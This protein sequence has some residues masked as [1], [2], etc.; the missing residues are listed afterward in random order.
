MKN[1]KALL[2]V[3]LGSPDRPRYKEVREYLSAFLND[4]RIIDIP[5]IFRKILV[6][7]F[8][9]PFRVKKS[10]RLYRKLWTKEGSPLLIYL[11]NL[12]YKL[13]RKLENQYQV[14]AGMRHGNS[15]LSGTLKQ[16][17][18]DN[19]EEIILLPLFP[20]Y[21][22]STTGSIIEKVICEIKHWQAIPSIR[23]IE[24]FYNH[25]A[26]IQTFAR[27]ILKYTP[28]KYDH[29]V[30]SYHG[31][32]IRHVN[33]IHPGITCKHC[34]CEKELPEYGRLCYKA[35]SYET[36]RLLVKELKI[37]EDKYSIGFQS[38]LSKKWIS[39]FTVDQIINLAQKGARK[40][41]VAAPSFVADCLETIVE[42]KDVYQDIFKYHGGK[43]LVLV[44]SLNDSEEWADALIK[45]IQ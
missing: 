4:R 23:I 34:I 26:F 22:S 18:D 24:Q 13:Q 25:P 32:P 33:K 37:P 3:N 35:T 11:N 10:T 5:W 12:S 38:C 36:T 20:Q 17:K 15:S 8:I 27:Q 43:E 29:I 16:I 2:I 9:I 19:V 42:I 28:I 30:F 44:K 21:A 7:L 1:K 40:I 6:N 41:L 39:P 14:Y 31:L 45:I